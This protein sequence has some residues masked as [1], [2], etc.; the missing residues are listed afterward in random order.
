MLFI[1]LS[2]EAGLLKG[3]TRAVAADYFDYDYAQQAWEEWNTLELLLAEAAKYAE[4][5]DAWK[6]DF[7]KSPAKAL[8]EMRAAQSGSAL[9]K[10]YD[11][12]L[13]YDEWR[14]HIYSMWWFRYKDGIVDVSFDQ[15]LAARNE[16]RAIVGPCTKRNFL[17]SCG[18]LPD[19]RDDQD[20][21]DEQA[22]MAEADKLHRP[23]K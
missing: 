19:W 11:L 7:K 23:K 5:F 16:R 10:G 8:R 15:W 1:P 22:M 9:Q 17:D 18:L 21:A 6:V 3:P 13:A 2:A 20:K 14:D 4:D 12:Q